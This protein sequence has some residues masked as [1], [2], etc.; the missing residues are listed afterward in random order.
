MKYVIIIEN[1]WNEF[2]SSEISHRRMDHINNNNK[3]QL[4]KNNNKVQYLK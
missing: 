1:W 3:V 4:I 2:F